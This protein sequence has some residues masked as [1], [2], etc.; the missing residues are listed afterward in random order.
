MTVGELIRELTQFAPDT[1][2]V[3]RRWSDL[4]EMEEPSPMK[5]F[6]SKGRDEYEEFY[7][8]QWEDRAGTK[9]FP[10]VIEACFFQG[11]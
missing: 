7:H 9:D 5:V 3:C 6:K 10:Q 1:L 4:I 8:K 11:N 2:V